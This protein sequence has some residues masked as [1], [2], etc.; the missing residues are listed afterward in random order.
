[1]G[2]R[3]ARRAAKSTLWKTA[4]G[5]PLLFT[6]RFMDP[7]IPVRRR[8][9][10]RMRYLPAGAFRM[11]SMCTQLNGCPERSVGTLTM[12]VITL[13]SGKVLC[14]FPQVLSAVLDSDFL[15]RERFEIQNG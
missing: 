15:G 2:R 4:V 8:S 1:M 3:L 12:Y 5:H 14:E 10:V 9:A 7:I 11:T 13:V 6:E